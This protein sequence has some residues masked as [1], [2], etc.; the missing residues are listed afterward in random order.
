MLPV[1]SIP[2]LSI[3]DPAL[4]A[5]PQQTFPSPSMSAFAFH[6]WPRLACQSYPS[7]SIPRL[8]CV[9]RP[10]QSSPFLVCLT[11]PEHS[12]PEHASP[13]YATALAFNDCKVI[14]TS[15]NSGEMPSAIATDLALYREAI[16]LA[17]SRAATSLALS[18][19]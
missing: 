15:S 16:A 12:V 8:P 10:F 6:V 17:N 13:A 5:T 11:L 1:P 4:S 14:N 3:P 18:L 9:S 19:S 7:H 2:I